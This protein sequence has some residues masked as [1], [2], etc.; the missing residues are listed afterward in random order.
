[1]VAGPLHIYQF[2]WS[3]AKR[4]ALS[5]LCICVFV[6]LASDSSGAEEDIHK[7]ANSTVV[8]R[9]PIVADQFKMQRS[10]W[11]REEPRAATPSAKAAL[12]G[13][14]QDSRPTAALPSRNSVPVSTVSDSSQATPAPIAD[15][16]P[17]RSY[18]LASGD[19]LTIKVFKY[20]DLSGEYVVRYDGSISLPVF[21]SHQV[22]GLEISDVERLLSERVSKITHG[23]SFVSAEVS[24]YRPFYV[25]GFVDKPG[26]YAW[27]PGLSVLHALTLAGGYPRIRAT[28]PIV[29]EREIGE[30]N[31]KP[32]LLKRALIRRA[33]HIAERDNRSQMIVPE[34]LR[35]LANDVEVDALVRLEQ[36]KLAERLELMK[37]KRSNLE[38]AMKHAKEQISLLIEKRASIDRQIELQTSLAMRIRKAPKG[39]VQNSRRMQIEIL[40]AEF[41]G[42]GR[43]IVREIAEAKQR[44]SDAEHRLKALAIERRIEIDL[45]LNRLDNQIATYNRT[46]ATSNAILARMGSSAGGGMAA[47]ETR[48]TYTVVRKQGSKPTTLT[49]DEFADVLPGDI[50]RVQGS[51]LALGGGG[52]QKSV[53]GIVNRLP[54]QRQE[55]ANFPLAGRAPAIR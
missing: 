50:L 34:R 49:V 38:Q 52:Q 53:S 54:L 22:A 48:V 21:G 42:E 45:E 46:I 24:R 6:S 36:R 9:N 14:V 19:A 30:L 41:V 15:S 3:A 4:V 2:R 37:S 35:T 20:K 7:Q 39:F 29:R 55:S 44:L 27:Q 40:L 23:Q 26:A 8:E 31:E 12:P 11:W 16:D 51:F 10:N 25:V 1:M 13:T 47:P 43:D 32:N 33:R 17:A 5:W 18:K 28:S